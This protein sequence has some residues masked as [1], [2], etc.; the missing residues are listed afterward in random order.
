MTSRA[1]QVPFTQVQD[2]PER[3]HAEYLEGESLVKMVNEDLIARRI[4]IKGCRD[5]IQHLHDQ[6]AP[7]RH[8]LEGILAL[9]G[10]RIGDAANRASR[11]ASDMQTIMARTQLREPV[12]P[13]DVVRS[14]GV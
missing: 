12:S 2:W 11:F 14:S 13:A 5:I 7:T 10:Q 6:D 3:I 4:S 8:R 9:K 1:N